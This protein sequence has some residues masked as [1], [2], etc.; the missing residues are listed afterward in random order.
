M[1]KTFKARL[2][3]PKEVKEASESPFG[4]VL[5][6]GIDIENNTIKGACLFGA[7]ESA[8]KRIYTDKAIDSITT[9]SEGV[10]CFINHPGRTEL[11][12]R[13]GV[14]DLRDWVGVYTNARRE[15]VKVFADL[16]CREEYFDLA[17]DIAL[18]QPASVGNSINARVKAFAGDDGMESIAD[19]DILRS[20]DLVSNAATTTSLFEA[21]IEENMED[22]ELVIGPEV[23]NSLV[24]TKFKLAM[25]QEGI[26]ADE[27]D[28][29]KIEQ[30]T[31]EVTWVANDLIYNTIRDDDLTI[32][33]KRNKISEIL[34]DLDEEIKKRLKSI[35]ENMEEENMDLTIDDLKSKHAPLV[36]TLLKEFKEGEE[37]DT[38]KTDLATANEKVTELETQVADNTTK[39][40]ENETT[41]T[42]LKSENAELKKK[43]DE[44][45]AGEKA[46]AKKEKIT[47]MLDTSKLPK[48]ART[49]IFMES[50]MEVEEED[51]IQKMID[52]R[53]S[54]A[55]GKKVVKSGEEFDEDAQ[56]S[57][58][59]E[60]LEDSKKTFL[61]N[62]KK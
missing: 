30:E 55:V 38:I 25:V 16:V 37:V 58:G 24:E 61:K 28:K 34:D 47:E 48:D 11:K 51:K 40:G 8:N 53:K 27:I 21:A 60:D 46:T 6:A 33:G 12:E 15:G 50:L 36:A 43:L 23:I 14:R 3:K 19:V 22:E 32:E 62:M 59:N 54:I 18:L 4:E 7:R 26:L 41:I 10:K 39:L 1:K 29:R 31:S 56:E 20:V 5:E 57:E 17:K 44:L 9:L 13:D 35:G 52:D 42:D 49:E 2:I 45:E